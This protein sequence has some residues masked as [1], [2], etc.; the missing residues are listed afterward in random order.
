MPSDTLSPLASFSSEWNRAEYRICNTAAGVDYLSEEEKTT[1]YILNLARMNPAFFA[2]TVV[3]V[4]PEYSG[5][6]TLTQSEYY[7]GLLTFLNKKTPMPLLYPE[8]TLF[9]SARCHATSSGEIGYV[10]HNRR[11]QACKRL[12]TF[13]GECCQYGYKDPLSIIMDLLIDEDVP[14]LGHRIILFKPHTQVGISIQPHKR[15]RWNAVLDLG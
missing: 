11:T 12:E 3:K 7:R 9:E 6:E 15:Y 13:M 2:K 1:L 5:E 4:Y 8:R 10:G 14:S